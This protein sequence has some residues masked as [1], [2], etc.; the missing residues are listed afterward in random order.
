MLINR[1][2]GYVRC[3]FCWDLDPEIEYNCCTSGCEWGTIDKYLNTE[4]RDSE[5][6]DTY[7]F[8][9]QMRCCGQIVDYSDIE[10]ILGGDYCM[11]HEPDEGWDDDGEEEDSNTIQESSNTIEDPIKA[12]FKHLTK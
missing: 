9:Y 10:D 7:D 5:T 3:P 4:C 11:D 8:E 12:L 2:G 1:R 6:T